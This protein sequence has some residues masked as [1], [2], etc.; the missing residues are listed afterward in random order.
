M[1][2]EAMLLAV[3]RDVLGLGAA[4]LTPILK[5]GSGR[6]FFRLRSRAQSWIVMHYGLERREN[7]L[8]ADI[9]VFLD[10][11]GVPVPAIIRHDAMR[12][13]LWMQDLGETDLHGASANGELPDLSLYE[14]AIS[15]V[16]VLHQQGWESARRGGL[17]LMP[18]FDE[19]LYAWERNYFYEEFFG[20]VCGRSLGA[21]E[22][23]RVE[24]DM[25]PLAAVLSRRAGDLVH[26]D[27]QSQN[28]IISGGRPFLIDFQG[29][30]PGVRHYDLASLI[31]DPYARLD[32]AGRERLIRFAFRQDA[33]G[34]SE[35][36][37]RRDL[38]L[39]AAQRL[40][41]ALGAYGMLGVK[42]GRTEFLQHVPRALFNLKFVLAQSGVSPALQEILGLL[43]Q[44]GGSCN[45]SS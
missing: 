21:A 34:Q 3:S 15:A 5:G 6:H 22:L 12:R 27:F 17:Q 45:P 16:V 20:G 26:R 23:E 25:S 1:V 14:A 37:F 24:A 11:L 38:N 32:G 29:L 10:K 4:T 33:G 42:K 2:S 7:A 36:E 41:Q 40:M 39:A 19:S 18:G 43:P 30:R 8:F 13:I 9:A 44:S 31:Y 35:S 28:I